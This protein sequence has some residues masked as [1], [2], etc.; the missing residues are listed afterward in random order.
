MEHNLELHHDE[1]HDWVGGDMG[2]VPRAAFDPAFYMHHA[3]IDY[4]FEEF[5]QNQITR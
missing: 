2:D 1:V 3:Y 5:R 4:I